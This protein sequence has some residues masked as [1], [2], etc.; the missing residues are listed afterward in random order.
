M[1]KI[2]LAGGNGFLGKA[3]FNHYNGLGY[4]VLVLT[5][6]KKTVF[7]HELFWDGKNLDDWKV[8]LNNTD[9]LINLS[10][11]SVDCRYT[12]H[13]KKQILASRIDSTAALQKALD[14]CDNPPKIWINA[15]T[16]T[17]YKDSRTHSNTEDSV[18]IGNDFSM[19]VAKKWEEEFF[20]VNA[21]KTRKVALRISLVLSNNGGV[22]PILTKLAKIG[23]GGKIGDGQQKFA[24]IEIEELIRMIDYIIANPTLS[25]PVNCSNLKDITNEE[26]MSQIRIANNIKFYLNIPAW[27]VALGAKIIGT[28]KELI[29]KSRYI[30]PQKLI[31]A[32]FQFN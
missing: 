20:K 5:R 24:H 17:I 22:L 1:K 4:N 31:D 30:K 12:E 18:E 10:G 11:K 13:N 27:M 23:L 29:L 26:F 28:E 15:S 32:G 8:E 7:K 19:T 2:I 16:A 6:N 9:V 21:P 3:L 14:L 25:G